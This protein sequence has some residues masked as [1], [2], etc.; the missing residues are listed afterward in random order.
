MTISSLVLRQ[1]TSSALLL[2]II[3]VDRGQKSFRIAF[4]FLS[5]EREEDYTW[6]LDH[7]VTRTLHC[8]GVIA[9]NCERALMDVVNSL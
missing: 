4:V 2:T 7:F 9:P 5:E 8:P 1:G 6:A 3:D